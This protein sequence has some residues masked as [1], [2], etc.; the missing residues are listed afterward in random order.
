VP[1]VLEAMRWVLP[2][3]AVRANLEPAYAN[4][5]TMT[6]ALLDRYHDLLL[7]PGNREAML[8]R[9]RGTVLNDPVRRLRSIGAPTLLVW[10][11]RDALIPVA[12]AD[13]YLRE[14]RG[15]SLV[16]LPG[17][18]HVP[19]EES[20]ERSADAVRD[21]LEGSAGNAAGEPKGP[22]PS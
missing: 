18:G 3:A 21:F 10:G 14:L 11:E 4:P 15:A 2:R 17:V 16:R 13:D 7:A 12:N 20:P 6:D 19:Q 5:A 9:M 1:T 22:G 8:Q